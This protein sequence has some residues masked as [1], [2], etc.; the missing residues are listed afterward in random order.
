MFVYDRRQAQARALFVLF[1]RGPASLFLRGAF[2]STL[3]GAPFG[4]HFRPPNSRAGKYVALIS[5][6]RARRGLQ[7][8]VLPSPRELPRSL[9]RFPQPSQATLDRTAP[10]PAKGRLIRVQIPMLESFFNC[11][12]LTLP[13]GL[14][15]ELTKQNRVDPIESAEPVPTSLAVQ[16]H[17]PTVTQSSE[18]IR[19][20]N[21]QLGSGNRILS[22]A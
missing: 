19:Y 1:L 3:F 10:G 21:E 6:E 14:K 9:S 22:L 8:P 5:A 17:R 4:G 7:C 16:Y 2:G 15:I 20:P 11:A 18:S 12:P 13:K